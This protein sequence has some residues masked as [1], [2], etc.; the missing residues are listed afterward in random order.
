MSSGV[1]I[2]VDGGKTV[3]L[4]LFVISLLTEQEVA[5]NTDNVDFLQ[6]RCRFDVFYQV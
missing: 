5:R 2:G 4:P 6:D 1:G 3:D